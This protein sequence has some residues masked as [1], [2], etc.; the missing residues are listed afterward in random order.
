MKRIANIIGAS[1]LV[2]QQLLSQ[3]LDHDEFEKVRSFVRRTSG[4]THPKL[5]EI[6]IDFDEPESWKHLVQGDILFSTLGTTIKAAK[7]KENQYLVDFTYQYEFAKAASE[8]GVETCILVSSMGAD[9]KSSIFY[10]RIKGELEEAVTLLPF[11]KLII[12]QPSILDGDRKEKRAGEKVGLIISRFATK[13]MLKNYRPTP[14]N[15]LAEK[16]IRV[17]VDSTP[18]FRLVKGTEI[19]SI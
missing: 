9:S 4:I 10:S 15:I 17:S 8:N 6:V 11:Q 5:E 19:F 12:F 2:G 13:F 7:T 16:M 1:G 18:G 3:L 14:V